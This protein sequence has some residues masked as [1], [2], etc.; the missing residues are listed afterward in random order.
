MNSLLVFGQ[1]VL[2]HFPDM[3]YNTKTHNSQRKLQFQAP[4]M[5]SH[6]VRRFRSSSPHTNETSYYA[7]PLLF[8][9][10]FLH[11]A[12]C[13]P[14]FWC[15][16]LSIL[17]TSSL[18]LAC[19]L[20]LLFTFLPLSALYPFLFP[21]FRSFSSLFI[22]SI[23]LLRISSHLTKAIQDTDVFFTTGYCN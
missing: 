23:Y 3:H 13:P 18:Y 4:G 5:L 2:C 8:S 16:F 15:P 7:T 12:L 20:L 6:T 11:F 19:L 17:L 14:L 22:L 21:S 1:H 10:P 9:V